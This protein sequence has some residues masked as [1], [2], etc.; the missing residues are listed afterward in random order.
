MIHMRRKTT[1]RQIQQAIKNNLLKLTKAEKYSKSTRKTTII[2][3]DT[4]KESLDFLCETIFSDAIG[5]HYE[6]D[7]RTGEYIIEA[8]RMDGDV[9]FI[10]IAHLCA[11]DDSNVEDIERILKFEEE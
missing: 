1:T 10:F 4:F 3:I 11:C 8:G 7:Y 9:D 2:S 5:W 6:R